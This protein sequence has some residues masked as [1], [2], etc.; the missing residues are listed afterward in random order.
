MREL[1]PKGLSLFAIWLK[2]IL[3]G[4]KRIENRSI[5]VANQIG[6]YRGPVLLTATLGHRVPQYDARGMPILDA[7]GRHVHKSR[8]M[9]MASGR[10]PDDVADQIRWI[11][12]EHWWKVIEQQDPDYAKSLLRTHARPSVAFRPELDIRALQGTCGHAVATADIVDVLDPPLSNHCRDY[13]HQFEQ[14][15]IR[16]DNV[17]SIV[18]I[19]VKGGQGF[20][21]VVQCPCGGV[22]ATSQQ[23]N[24]R[25][26]AVS[27]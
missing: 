21:G 24:H 26:M 10:M 22:F 8:P 23:R 25:C 15:G 14:Y 13:W 1:P 17:Q 3:E 18:P 12:D 27:S 16:L 6:T 20:W 4:G 2:F 5:Y 9:S 7:K 19:P 11:W